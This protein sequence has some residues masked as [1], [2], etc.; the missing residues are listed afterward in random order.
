MDAFVFD[1]KPAP[2]RRRDQR[3]AFSFSKI[4]DF[5]IGETDPPRRKGV[6]G[7]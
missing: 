5:A 4:K 7:A 6:Q 1:A 3:E 2:A